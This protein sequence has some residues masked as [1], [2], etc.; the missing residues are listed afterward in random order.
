MMKGQSHN[1]L[2]AVILCF[3]PNIYAGTVGDN[4]AVKQPFSWTGAYIGG[5]V[6]GLFQSGN[7]S[8]APYGDTPVHVALNPKLGGSSAIGGLLLGFNDQIG[9]YVI[10]VEGDVGWMKASSTVLSAA[11]SIPLDVWYASNKLTQDVNG[12]LRGRVGYAPGPFL[13]FVSGGLAITSAKLNTDGYFI[14]LLP[15]IISSDSKTLFG[16]TVGFGAEY[17]IRENIPVRFE[18]FY[19]Q[20]NS[21]T[22]TPSPTPGTNWQNRQLSLDNNTFRVSIAYKF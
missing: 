16:W 13:L 8:L 18:Y 4:D 7:L 15:N 10:G 20:Y 3:A 12:H 5:H 1:L 19:D 2:A 11:T 14:S 22:M 21:S 9:Q 6:G 17:A